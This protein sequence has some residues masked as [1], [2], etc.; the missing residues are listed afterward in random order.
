MTR[1]ITSQ[2]NVL[3]KIG[4]ISLDNIFKMV[5]SLQGG[6]FFLRV[7]ILT[8]QTMSIIGV[9]KCTNG[10]VHSTYHPDYG[11]ILNIVLVMRILR[12]HCFKN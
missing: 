6:L 5:P 4:T 9:T 12:G 7:H 3:A 1:M 8:I 11:G 10:E 2:Y